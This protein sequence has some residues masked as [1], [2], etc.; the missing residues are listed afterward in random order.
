MSFNTP[1]QATQTNPLQQEDS[2][3][4]TLLDCC[5]RCTPGS[6]L[7]CCEPVK[8]WA[9]RLSD[10]KYLFYKSRSQHLQPDDYQKVDMH[11]CVTSHTKYTSST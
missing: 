2:M 6:G 8:D 1:K 5:Q 9:V 3:A 11:H 7:C 4:S 10:G